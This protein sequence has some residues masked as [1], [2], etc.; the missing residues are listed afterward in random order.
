MAVSRAFARAAAVACLVVT[1]SSARGGDFYFQGDVGFAA[2]AVE[3]GGTHT[4]FAPVQLGGNDGD[5]TPVFGGVLGFE[6][7][8]DE[9]LP[10]EVPLPRWLGESFRLPAWKLRAE[11][12][13][14]YRLD[15]EFMT[16]GVSPATP[17]RAEVSTWSLF[18]N[19]W[20][21]FPVHPPF[22]WIFGR[23]PILEPLTLYTGAGLG[24]SASSLTASDTVVSGDDDGYHFAWQAG[25]GL[26]YALT[27][28]AHIAVGYRYVDLG[29]V[30]TDLSDGPIDSG[31]FSL[32]LASHEITT[33]LRFDF[34][35]VDLPGRPR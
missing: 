6:S 22:E 34:F 10:F 4:R 17:F 5:T 2:Q 26:S 25:A 15:S 28:W 18:N 3:S 21:H 27:E 24:M 12:E 19:V 29:S 30:E 9:A 20:M 11:L 33:G 14:R 23:I 1:G 32:D 35:S 31:S 16:D 7:P 13:G 8:L